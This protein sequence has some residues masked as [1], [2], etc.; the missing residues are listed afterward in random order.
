MSLG[1]IPVRQLHN[2]ARYLDEFHPAAPGQG[3]WETKQYWEL[4]LNEL[5]QLP[6][7]GGRFRYSYAEVNLPAP[8]A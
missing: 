1:D 6:G 3:E 5:A 8:S 2:V 4:L 7:S